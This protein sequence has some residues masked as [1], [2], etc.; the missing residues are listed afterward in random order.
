MSAAGDNANVVL[1]ERGAAA[2][3]FFRGERGRY[4][5]ELL[6]AA[7]A[8]SAAH[9]GLWGACPAARLDPARAVATGDLR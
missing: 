3:Y 8:A 7:A 1:V 6:D 9:R 2:P 4:S 5:D